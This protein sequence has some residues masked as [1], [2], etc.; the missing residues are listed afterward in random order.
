MNTFHPKGFGGIKIKIAA[1]YKIQV[2]N[3]GAHLET[4]GE[5]GHPVWGKPMSRQK[6]R[7]M[8]DELRRT[9]KYPDEYQL[10]PVKV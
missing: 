8:I 3:G 2:W 5:P 9:K 1:E 4:I 10:I 7:T 6:A